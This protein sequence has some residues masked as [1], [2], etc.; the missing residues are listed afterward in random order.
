MIVLYSLVAAAFLLS[1]VFMVLWL[2]ERRNSRIENIVYGLRTN[3]D[4]TE[5]TRTNLTKMETGFREAMSK[6]EDMGE[7]SCNEWGQW[8]WTKSGKPVGDILSNQ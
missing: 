1:M 6:L 8:I 7:V 5:N 4:N 3:D 2:K